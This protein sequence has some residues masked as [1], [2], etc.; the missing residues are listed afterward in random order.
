LS[1]SF[2]NASPKLG[3]YRDAPEPC[4]ALACSADQ[5]H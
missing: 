3:R 4:P 2:R 5:W 1:S